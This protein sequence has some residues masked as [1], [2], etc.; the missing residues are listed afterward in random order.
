MR[1][2][3]LVRPALFHPP[4]RANEQ[5]KSLKACVRR[6]TPASGRRSRARANSIPRTR[7]SRKVLACWKRS[8]RLLIAACRGASQRNT[9]LSLR[10]RH[11]DRRVR[12]FVVWMRS[13][14]WLAA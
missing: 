2:Y 5:H 4:A 11:A 13:L 6:E 7:C 9:S 1:P 3:R 8:E 12:L 14:T 10:L